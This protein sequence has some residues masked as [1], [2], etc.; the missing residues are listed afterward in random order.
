M[1]ERRRRVILYYQQQPTFAKVKRWAH[2]SVDLI[3]ASD[4]ATLD[5]TLRLYSQIDAVVAERSSVD[6]ASLDVLR[7]AVARRPATPRVMLVEQEAMAGVCEALHEKLITHLMFLPINL[8][9]LSRSTGVIPS[10]QIIMEP[11]PRRRQPPLTGGISA[12]SSSSFRA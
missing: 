6:D 8:D 12:S 9:E 5:A 4:L 2:R 11:L 1:T 10:T 7:A 3:A